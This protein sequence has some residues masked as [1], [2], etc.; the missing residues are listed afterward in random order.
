MQ[1]S[2]AAGGSPSLLL[3]AKAAGNAPR[4]AER[5][6]TRPPN[7]RLL[8]SGKTGTGTMLREASRPSL[9]TNVGS[10]TALARYEISD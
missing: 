4:H 10:A 1:H 6:M 8:G 9:W 3:T 7:G 2:P 5:S